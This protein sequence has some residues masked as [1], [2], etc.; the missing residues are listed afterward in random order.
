MSIAQ[1]RC[2]SEMS[3]VTID[4]LP[5]DVL[6]I[7]FAFYVDDTLWKRK[8]KWPTLAHVCR[9]WRD[10]IF[11][12]PGHLNLQLIHTWRTDIRKT[13]DVWTPSLPIF[14]DA[15]YLDSCGDYD[16]LMA[17][18][19]HNDRICGIKLRV[20]CLSN[21]Q[22]IKVFTA[23]EMPFLKLTDVDFL[24]RNDLDIPDSFLVGHA[25]RLRKL[26][27]S[28]ASFLGLPKLLLYAPDL[29]ELI[30]LSVPHSGYISPEAMGS[31]LSTLTRLKTFH[32]T[33][34]SESR[35]WPNRECRRP[36]PP[37]RTVLP[38]LT[39]FLF[40]GV[41][42][43]LED[44]VARIDAPLLGFLK[45]KF[46]GQFVSGAPQLAQFISRS[47]QLR[48]H[49][50]THVSFS[51]VG[52]SVTFLGTLDQCLSLVLRNPCEYS[53]LKLR[54]P[55]VKQ[56]CG[57]SFPQAL[58]QFTVVNCLYMKHDRCCLLHATKISEWLKIFRQFTAVKHIYLS[59]IFMPLV[60]S[61]L[62]DI[63][64]ERVTEVFPALGRLFV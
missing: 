1:N 7:A 21:W 25:P 18:L 53:E 17:M 64:R 9:K 45:I 15:D 60:T 27:L 29:V 19:E 49:D 58:V 28:G 57:S 42:E 32:F 35:R 36:L 46:L 47:P 2:D 51:T 59:W 4:V 43:Y 26:A 50:E 6:L 5:D 14:I 63:V 39:D 61:T 33:L 23:M 20:N 48:A 13:L 3:R 16:D 55:F 56:V 52:T 31:C 54:V 22:W 38:A 30:L 34:T 41:D 11:S 37:T 12:W 44:L 62:Q 8:T 10:N 40:G 24:S